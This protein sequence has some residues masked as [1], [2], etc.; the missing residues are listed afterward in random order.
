MGRNTWRGDVTIDGQS[1]LQNGYP[2][3]IKDLKADQERDGAIT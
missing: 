3:D 1:E 2:V